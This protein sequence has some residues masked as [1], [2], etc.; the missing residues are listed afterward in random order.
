[1]C[2]A[3]DGLIDSRGAVV[4]LTRKQRQAQGSAA[5]SPDVLRSWRRVWACDCD[6]ESHTLGGYERTAA[7]VAVRK[8]AEHIRQITGHEPPTCPWR[9]Y[10]EPIVKAVVHL[11]TLAADGL[12]ELELGPD[13]AAVIL[14]AYATYLRAY[15]ATYADEMEAERAERE[16]K[17]KADAARRPKR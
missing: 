16:A 12:A 6:G 15:N 17:R 5:S 11:R 8:M 2:G 13:P 4:E 10:Y 7:S 9:V 3:Q 14:D 1:M